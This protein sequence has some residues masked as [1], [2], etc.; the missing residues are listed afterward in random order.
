MIQKLKEEITTSNKLIDIL[1]EHY[2]KEY[3]AREVAKALI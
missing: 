3:L 2:L 1:D